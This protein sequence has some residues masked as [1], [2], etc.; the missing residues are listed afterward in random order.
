MKYGNFFKV[1][2]MFQDK[3]QIKFFYIETKEPRPT[4]QIRIYESQ[5]LKSQILRF[6]VQCR[7][8]IRF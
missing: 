6:I 5:R 4:R 1:T 3:V 7:R 2:L 8:K